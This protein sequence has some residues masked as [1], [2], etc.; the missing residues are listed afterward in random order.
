MQPSYFERLHARME[1]ELRGRSNSHENSVDWA[2]RSFTAIACHMIFLTVMNIWWND[3]VMEENVYR[4]RRYWADKRKLIRIWLDTVRF[5]DDQE[6]SA[7]YD[8]R[9]AKLIAYKMLDEFCQRQLMG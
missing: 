5:L 6:L 8:L 4:Q 7:S 2:A 1:Q 9:V 3:R